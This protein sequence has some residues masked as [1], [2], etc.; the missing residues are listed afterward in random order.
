MN[1]QRKDTRDNVIITW[2]ITAKNSCEE[3]R[4]RFQIFDCRMNE[5]VRS[6]RGSPWDTFE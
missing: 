4:K 1:F 2:Y 3:Y 6:W 5:K